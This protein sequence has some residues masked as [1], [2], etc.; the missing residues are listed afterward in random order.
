[1]AGYQIERCTGAGCSNFALQTTVTT[2]SYNNTG[3]AASTSYSYRVRA[4]DA[5][6][7][8]SGYTNIGTATTLATPD[9]TAPSAPTNLAAGGITT[10]AIN[11][12]WTASTDNVGVTGYLIERC[13]GSSC[14]N[15]AQIG[16]PAVTTYSD[17]G[18]AA[19][20]AYRYRV[21]A[22]DAANNLSGYS[23]IV[24]ATTPAVP[25]TT[26]PT[27]TISAPTSAATFSTSTSPLNLGGTAADNVG[28]TQVSWTN[29]RGGSGT[30]TGTHGLVGER[31]CA[32]ERGQRTHGDGAGCGGEH[33]HGHP[34]GHV[35][36]AAARH[37]GADRTRG[38]WSDGRFGLSN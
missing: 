37:D 36:A 11:L 19:S 38:S 23:S 26:V 5:A 24:T 20:T 1:M 16:T 30:A 6:G 9:T 7:N 18:L 27:V 28:V 4:T 32:A 2:T 22:T 33:R 12:S 14:S 3:L 13:Q 17:T 29:D 35:Y 21:R 25:D 31:H 10:N 15:F 34:H 8:L